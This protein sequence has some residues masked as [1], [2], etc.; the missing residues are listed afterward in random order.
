MSTDGAVQSSLLLSS[1]SIAASLGLLLLGVML[2]DSINVSPDAGKGT[3]RDEGAVE[4]LLHRWIGR[5]L[6]T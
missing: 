5:R 4:E 2:L 6:T 3:A 1:S